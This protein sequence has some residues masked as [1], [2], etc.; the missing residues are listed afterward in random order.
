VAVFNR[1]SI[2]SGECGAFGIVSMFMVVSIH[3]RT[4]YSLHFVMGQLA[5]IL[6]GGKRLLGYRLSDLSSL[7]V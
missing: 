1:I 2:C 3:C 7:L 4:N 6:P 5:F